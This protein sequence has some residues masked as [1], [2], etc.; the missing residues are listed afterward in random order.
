MAHNP[1]GGLETPFVA[2]CVFAKDK[3]LYLCAHG[4]FVL[5]GGFVLL[6]LEDI[7]DKKKDVTKSLNDY[8]AER[9]GE[10]RKLNQDMRRAL[11][12]E[13]IF[14]EDGVLYEPLTVMSKLAKGAKGKKTG[15]KRLSVKT[16]F[17]PKAKA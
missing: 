16:K 1:I 9:L 10:F 4:V 15:M 11:L 17:A 13:L 2:I 12:E 7:N 14:K 6:S 3:I 5:Y 8:V